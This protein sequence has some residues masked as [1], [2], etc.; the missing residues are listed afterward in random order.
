M[1][2]NNTVKGLNGTVTVDIGKASKE[3]LDML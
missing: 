1:Q 3:L 2:A